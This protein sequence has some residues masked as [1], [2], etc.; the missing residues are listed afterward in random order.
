MRPAVLMSCSPA[1][2][3][4]TAVCVCE[5]NIAQRR[6]NSG[7]ALATDTM[8]RGGLYCAESGVAQRDSVNLAASGGAAVYCGNATRFSFS[9]GWL[10]ALDE[11][12]WNRTPCV[13]D[14][15]SQ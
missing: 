3:D 10:L 7:I 8:G 14:S 9:V 11:F 2:A 1:M 4:A 15:G 12:V 13:K 6:G 5:E